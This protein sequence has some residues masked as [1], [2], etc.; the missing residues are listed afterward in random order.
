MRKRGLQTQ[1][2]G[3]CHTQKCILDKYQRVPRAYD[4][5]N[6]T[7]FRGDQ[8]FL[9]SQ[10]S[11]KKNKFESRIKPSFMLGLSNKSVTNIHWASFLCYEQIILSLRSLSLTLCV[12]MY[13]KAKQVHGNVQAVKAFPLNCS[14]LKFSFHFQL[15][16]K[17]FSPHENLSK[18]FKGKQSFCNVLF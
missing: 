7:L 2:E 13:S 8:F 6:P 1:N 9:N 5:L 10:D 17:H 15:N 4:Y 11:N 16:F 18:N 14:C 12:N 3:N